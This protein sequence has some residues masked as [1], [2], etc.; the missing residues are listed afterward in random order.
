MLPHPLH[1]QV[2]TGGLKEGCPKPVPGET[3]SG[4]QADSRLSV[5]RARTLPCSSKGRS[6]TN[7]QPFGGCERD[8]SVT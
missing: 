1:A 5:G 7:R 3:S 2:T 8:I 4:L 6:R